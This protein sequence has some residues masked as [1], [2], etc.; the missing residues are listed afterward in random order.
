MTEDLPESKNEIS[1]PPRRV[2]KTMLDVNLVEL[3]KQLDRK[4]AKTLLDAPLPGGEKP[5]SKT[6][7]DVPIPLPGESSDA[8]KVAK[9]MLD[10]PL[11]K[12]GGT[13]EKLVE[14]TIDAPEAA[15]DGPEATI[16]AP[17]P[18][19]QHFVAKTRL[20]HEILSITLRKYED[21]KELIAI[22]EAR[23]RANLPPKELVSKTSKKFARK[24]PWF[25]PE[26]AEGDKFLYCAKC[27]TAVYNFDGMELPEAEALIFTRENKKSPTLYKRDDGKFMTRD[28]PIQVKKRQRVILGSVV[29]ATLL[30]ASAVMIALSPPSTAP[31]SSGAVVDDDVRDADSSTGDSPDSSVTRSARSRRTGSAKSDQ[32][33]GIAEDNAGS[34]S[35][36]TVNGKR[37][38]P[39]FGPEDENAYW[40]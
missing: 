24:C 21:R 38:R 11:P 40:E 20:D 4:V 6:L 5:V 31:T 34:S 7:L 30:L 28:C 39:V 9:T 22:E 37:K 35:I 27:K 10:L 36:E 17:Q 14:A 13:T 8:G 2:A 23:E 25:W 12:E 16:G 33:G 26:Q 32:G 29:V 19:R 18:R 15:I 3:R 1:T